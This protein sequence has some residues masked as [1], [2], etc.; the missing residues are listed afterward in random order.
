VDEEQRE[1]YR[2]IDLALRVGEVVMS[3]GA[4]AADVSAT[5]LSV[6]SA[7]GLRGCTVDVNFTT[8]SVA[9]QPSPD[10]APETHMRVVQY[11]GT[12]YGLL[13]EVDNLVRDL[14]AGRVDRTEAS[15]RLNEIRSAPRPYP[16][17]AQTLSTGVM[18]L[19][20]GLLLGG[21]WLVLLAAFV[22]AVFIDLALRA[23]TRRRI[24]LFFQQI[25]GALI[26][27]GIALG[28][29][30]LHAPAPPSLIIASGIIILLAG[31]SLVGAVQDAL[32]GYYVTASAR[33]FEVMMLTGGIIGGIVIGLG[34]AT[35][36][37]LELSIMPASTT[38][39]E[40][41][42]ALIGATLTAVAFAYGVSAPMRALVPIGLTALIGETTYVI[43]AQAGL[44]ITPASGL[45]AMAVGVVSFSLAGRVR[46][47][48]LIV[49][50]SGIVPL[51]PGLTIYRGLF[52]ITDNDIRGM[53]TLFTAIGIGVALAA[54][55]Y[56]GESLAQPLKREAR[57]LENRLAGP[58]LVGPL[59]PVARRSVRRRAARRRQRASEEQTGESAAAE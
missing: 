30:A 48:A 26:A 13:T 11:R 28:L 49:V 10:S 40:I 46:V 32:T 5:M 23:M 58:R 59:V 25:V 19:A 33:V 51:L 41:P 37:G 21:N 57:R 39:S 4:G 38:W 35:G 7:C 12:D 47:P 36:L 20:V 42:M 31:A 18:A 16:R 1:V 34:V 54:G 27:T 43:A 44:T 55:V 29:H 15:Q 2:A 8:L 22:S 56:L 6:T 52:L 9:Y 45:A 3:S 50:V 14:G 17:W 24:A 53:F